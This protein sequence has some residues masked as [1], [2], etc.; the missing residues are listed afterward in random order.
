[1]RERAP[2]PR[3]SFSWWGAALLVAPLAL[4]H[5]AFY[6]SSPKLS[7]EGRML[8]FGGHTLPFGALDGSGFRLVAQ[9]LWDYEPALLIAGAAGLACG[10]ARL[11]RRGPPREDAAGG[12]RRADLLV[13]SAYAL[14]YLLALGLMGLTQ[15]RFL[16]P[17]LPF[18]ACLAAWPVALARARPALAAF[19][20][21]LVVAF[22][23]LVAARFALLRAAPDTYERAARWV[24]EHV[25]P[26]EERVATSA[27]LALPLFH[28]P[29][30]LRAAAEDY[31]TRQNL[32]I[33]WQLEHL[34][35]EDDAPFAGGER[36]KLLLAPG[37]LLHMN[38]EHSRE[39]LETW[40]AA[41]DADYA[42]LER[43]RRME[44]IPQAAALRELIAERGE[45]VAAIRG[46][47]ERWCTERP[48]D[49]QEIPDFVPRILAATAFGPCLEIYRLP[50]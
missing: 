33:R 22:P 32:W 34:P 27:S 4:V 24:A 29:E 13:A 45:L 47:D 26:A 35:L 21:A 19:L 14:P 10:T 43:S 38:R 46:E 49:Y 36:W 11:I 39:E 18:L 7:G 37:K 20:A 17:L 15:D 6:P 9:Y 1:L 16:L 50:R 5:W 48:Q 3:P 2:R 41:T 25:D 42:V 44:F 8:D 12:A 31:A 30:A 23:V 40:L 28:A